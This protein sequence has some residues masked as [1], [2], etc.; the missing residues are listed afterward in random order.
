MTEHVLKQLQAENEILKSENSDLKGRVV[1]LQK[2]NDMA[3]LN[4]ESRVETCA[5]NRKRLEKSKK[6][7][8]VLVNK[9]KELEDQL[10]QHNEAEEARA[11]EPRA[12]EEKA[13]ERLDVSQKKVDALTNE[14]KCVYKTVATL[15]EKLVPHEKAAEIERIRLEVVATRE[16][17]MPIIS[18]LEVARK[19]N[20][21]AIKIIEHVGSI[22]DD[23]ENKRLETETDAVAVDAVAVGDVAVGDVAA[24]AA[25]GEQK[26]GTATTLVAVHPPSRTAFMKAFEAVQNLPTDL[27]VLGMKKWILDFEIYEVGLAVGTI[28]P[29]KACL[30]EVYEATNAVLQT[31]WLQSDAIYRNKKARRVALRK[32]LRALSSLQATSKTPKEEEAKRGKKIISAM[33][34]SGSLGFASKQHVYYLL[35]FLLH[36]SRLTSRDLDDDSTKIT[37]YPTQA[38][39]AVDGRTSMAAK[40]VDIM[41]KTLKDRH[42]LLRVLFYDEQGGPSNNPALRLNCKKLP[43]IKKVW[44]EQR[45]PGW[46]NDKN[47]GPALKIAMGWLLSGCVEPIAFAAAIAIRKEIASEKVGF[48]GFNDD[49]SFNNLMTYTVGEDETTYTANLLCLISHAKRKNKKLHTTYDDIWKLFK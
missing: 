38:A 22:L 49:N 45:G 11:E 42:P 8:E 7:V 46:V 48:N 17:H 21:N 3:T 41:R 15:K 16:P 4:L 44:S 30:G 14:L 9:I 36:T 24:D 25:S 43:D 6:K 35:K 10:H 19:E 34:P 2:N 18:A 27:T 26:T 13:S 47:S 28:G 33:R 23:L 40:F 20:G 29:V 31:Q 32:Y 12:E 5:R 1:T 39:M 37:Y